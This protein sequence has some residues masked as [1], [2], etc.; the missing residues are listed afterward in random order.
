[1]ILLIFWICLPACWKAQ[2]TQIIS[3]TLKIQ[4]ISDIGVF[5][6]TKCKIHL[7]NLNYNFL[8]SPLV[9]QCFF[10]FFFLFWTWILIENLIKKLLMHSPEKYMCLCFHNFKGVMTLLKFIP[11]PRLRTLG[12]VPRTLLQKGISILHKTY[13]SNVCKVGRGH[14]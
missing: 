2:R 3:N 6:R 5:K 13:C 4:M 1:M 9:K 8:L 12:T 11:T 7:A 10:D 14:Y